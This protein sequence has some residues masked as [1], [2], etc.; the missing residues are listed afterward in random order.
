MAKYFFHLVSSDGSSSQDDIGIDLPDAEAAYLEGCAAALEIS[1]EMLRNRRDPSRHA[2]EITDAE[3]RVV[4]ELP[5]AEVTRPAAHSHPDLEEVRAS[6]AVTRDYAS[7]NM[8]EM[9][10]DMR[11]ARAL[12]AST[13]AILAK[14]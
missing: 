2:F 8:R 7:R 1:Y 5:F 13:R 3:G 14:V 12:L 4:F 9:R 10:T 6:I 11:R